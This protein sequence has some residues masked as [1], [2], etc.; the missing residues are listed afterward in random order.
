[1]LT[2]LYRQLRQATDEEF[3]Q[4][5]AQILHRS[6]GVIFERI[7]PATAT[8]KEIEAAFHDFVPAQHDRMASL[9][10]GLCRLARITPSTEPFIASTIIDRQ[11]AEQPRFD[12]SSEEPHMN[13]DERADDSEGTQLEAIGARLSSLDRI[14]RLSIEIRSYL[15]SLVSQNKDLPP[16]YDR[17]SPL[18]FD[19]PGSGS[20]TKRKRDRW[21]AALNAQIDYLI[22]IEDVNN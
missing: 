3:S 9:F 21:I 8:S 12:F 14:E 1:M 16:F 5:L 7:D 11:I 22:D 15:S 10:I 18:L 17:L 19:L 13:N 2:D 6:Y 4:I 20:W